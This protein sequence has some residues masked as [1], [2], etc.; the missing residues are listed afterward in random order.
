M[1]D[2][3]ELAVAASAPHTVL[4]GM[5]FG[6]WQGQGQD[7]KGGGRERGLTHRHV[8]ACSHKGIGH[9]VDELAA[10][11]KVAQLDFTTR[12][13]QDVGGLHVCRS[14]SAT[15]RANVGEMEG[16]KGI[17]RS[18]EAKS[19]KAQIPPPGPFPPASLQAS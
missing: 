5:G 14:Q 8:R 17:R 4:L 1:Q 7:W 13:H 18:R 11:A 10:H 9:G 15:E 12:V 3:A 19:A 16:W 2:W 6:F